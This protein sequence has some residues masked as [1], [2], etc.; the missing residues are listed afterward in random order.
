MP[1]QCHYSYQSGDPLREWI[2]FERSIR[3][4]LCLGSRGPPCHNHCIFETIKSNH[5]L[6]QIYFQFIHLTVNFYQSIL[7]LGWDEN[8][9]HVLC[10][11][12]MAVL[13]TRSHNHGH[14]VSTSGI[15]NEVGCHGDCSSIFS[16]L[17]PKYLTEH[18]IEEKIYFASQK[19]QICISENTAHGHLSP[20]LEQDIM[21]KDI[22]TGKGWC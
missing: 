14:S 19:L 1:L 17:W 10:F 21:A 11:V 3:F 18:V 7:R 6:D 5:S 22:M 2:I 16:P 8:W 20:E 9:I 13:H 4:S 12:K 15:I